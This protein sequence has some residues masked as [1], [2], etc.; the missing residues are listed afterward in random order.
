VVIY[1]KRLKEG[2][3]SVPQQIKDTTE[4]EKRN[5]RLIQDLE[6]EIRHNVKGRPETD[7][8]SVK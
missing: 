6:Q 3:L 7:L 2:N 4:R 1:N 5:L 8:A